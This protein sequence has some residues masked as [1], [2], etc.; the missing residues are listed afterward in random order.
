MPNYW[1]FKEDRAKGLIPFMLIAT[2]G[3]TSTCGV[4]HLEEIGPVCNKEGIW[5]HVDAAYAG[6]DSK[7]AKKNILGNA[8]T[9]ILLS[10]R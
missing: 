10:F 4:D 1:E 3:T 8:L 7:F 2:V 9:L 5:L 6:M